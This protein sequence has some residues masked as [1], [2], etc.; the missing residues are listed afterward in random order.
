M[1][2]NGIQATAQIRQLEA[3]G[4]LSGQLPIL[5]VSANVRDG[6]VEEMLASGM[7][8]PTTF[9][10]RASSADGYSAQT[11]VLPKPCKLARMLATIQT[12]LSAKSPNV[13]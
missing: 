8:R 4:R 1:K 13:V 2:V 12:I 7:V 6:Q 5:G 3:L 9:T 10:S 11:E